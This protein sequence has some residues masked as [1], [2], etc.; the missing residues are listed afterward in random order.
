MSISRLVI[1]KFPFSQHFKAKTT[2]TYYIVTGMITI[3]IASTVTYISYEIMEHNILMPPST[4]LFLSENSQFITVKVITLVLS[5]LQI[6]SFLSILII[7]IIVIKDMSKTLI[8]SSAKS[9]A[10]KQVLIQSVLITITNA[11]CWLPSSAICIASL[12]METH[13]TGLLIWNVILINPLN[14]VV[15]PITFCLVPLAKRYM[16][17][18][19]P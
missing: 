19:P 18:S 11:L 3:V 9:R 15:N 7:Y 14:S 16:K 1:V 17:R 12:A 5:I 6:G 13:P 2:I 8:I 4:C 10:D